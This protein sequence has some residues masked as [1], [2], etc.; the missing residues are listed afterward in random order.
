VLA[1]EPTMQ[2]MPAKFGSLSGAEA[3]PFLLLPALSPLSPRDVR[4]SFSPITRLER[5]TF[6]MAPQKRIWP[7]KNIC[8]PMH[9]QRGKTRETIKGLMWATISIRSAGLRREQIRGTISRRRATAQATIVLINSVARTPPPSMRCCATVPSTLLAWI[10]PRL[11]TVGFAIGPIKRDSRA[12]IR[13]NPFLLRV[14]DSAVG[15][16]LRGPNLLVR[17]VENDRFGCLATLAWAPESPKNTAI[18]PRKRE[19]CTRQIVFASPQSISEYKSWRVRD[20]LDPIRANLRIF[21]S[22]AS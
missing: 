11:I 7:S 14:A 12:R 19:H 21:D 2:G 5:L 1:R 18:C 20:L 3:L 17:Q 9:I 8:V 10:Y 22:N 15:C 4:E 16:G 13:Y 6:S